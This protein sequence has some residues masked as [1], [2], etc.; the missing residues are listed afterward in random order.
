MSILTFFNKL[1]WLV[2]KGLLDF[3]VF[4]EVI[5]TTFTNVYENTKPILDEAEKRRG[6]RTDLPHFTYLYERMKKESNR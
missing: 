6:R 3:D 4:T 2:K 1:G 5:T